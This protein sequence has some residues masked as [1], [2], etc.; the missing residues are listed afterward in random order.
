M[1]SGIVNISCIRIR[2]SRLTHALFLFYLNSC[3]RPS[4]EK[5]RGRGYLPRPVE[6]EFRK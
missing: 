4:N 1:K 6:G 5:G 2:I 3:I